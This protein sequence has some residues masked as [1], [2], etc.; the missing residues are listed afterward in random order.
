MVPGLR[1][2]LLFG[3]NTRS[4]AVAIAPMHAAAAAAINGLQP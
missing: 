4:I 2:G 3:M 1:S